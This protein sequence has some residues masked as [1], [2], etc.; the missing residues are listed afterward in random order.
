MKT[1]N[2]KE[3]YPFIVVAN[4]IEE[5]ERLGMSSTFCRSYSIAIKCMLRLNKYSGTTWHIKATENEQLNWD[6]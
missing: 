6:I 2:M 3:L 4:D 5:A 1:F